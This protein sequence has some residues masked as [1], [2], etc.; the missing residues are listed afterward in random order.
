MGWTPLFLE[1]KDKKVFIAGSGEVGI[2]RAKTFLKAGARVKLAGSDLPTELSN[3]GAKLKPL[4]E[5]KKWVKWAD[6]VVI[7]TG[8]PVLNGKIATL[9]GGKLLNRADDPDGGNVI[10]PSSF[11]VGDVQICIFTH[12]KSPLM[13]RE[14]RKKIQKV[15]KNEDVLQI[16]LQDFARKMLKRNVDNQKQRKSYLYE[17]SKDEKVDKLL[18]NGDLENAKIYVKNIYRKFI[19]IPIELEIRVYQSRFRW[20]D[21]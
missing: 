10:V 12:G 16:E 18:K 17:I 14:L 7:A 9:S 5:Y 4:Q 20:C 2:R 11:L 1:M 19:I 8:D 6:L 15:I 3:L 13:S 21:N